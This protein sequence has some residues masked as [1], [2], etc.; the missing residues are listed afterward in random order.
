M[1]GSITK[2]IKPNPTQ[3]LP[4]LRDYVLTRGIEPQPNVLQTFVRT[5]YTTTAKKKLARY[6]KTRPT[7]S[8]E[9]VI[10]Q[11]ILL[12]SFVNHVQ[13]NS[14]RLALSDHILNICDNS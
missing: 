12:V 3:L 11:F 8:N 13:H 6:A 9:S 7:D 1:I 10:R 2:T 5:S 14:R 4:V